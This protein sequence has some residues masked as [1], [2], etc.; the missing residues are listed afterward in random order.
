MIRTTTLRRWNNALHRDIGYLAFGMTIIYALS[1]IVL[2]HFKAGDF[3]HPDYSASVKTFTAPLPSDSVITQ[4]Y[5]MSVLTQIGETSNYKSFVPGDG[6]LNIFLKTGSVYIDLKTGESSLQKKTPRYVIKEFNLL[7]YNNIKKFFTW[8]SD[9]YAVSLMVLAVTGLFVLK[10]KNGIL[11]RGA[12]LT[13]IGIL[14][15]AL[16]LLFYS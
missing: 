1:G 8:F 16:F 14:L 3:A 2:N 9:L 7:H 11:K 15:P 10:G 13:A 12:W 6:Y 5:V 4:A